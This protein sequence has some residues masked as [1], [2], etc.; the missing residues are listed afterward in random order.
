LFFV[1]GVIFFNVGGKFVSG[2]FWGGGGGGGV[3]SPGP[4]GGLVIGVDKK[5]SA[6]LLKYSPQS[7]SPKNGEIA[8]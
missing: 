2:V 7:I 6:H 1:I 3:G 5:I 4:P 8:H